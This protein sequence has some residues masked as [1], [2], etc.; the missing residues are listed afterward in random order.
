M[1][2][3]AEYQGIVKT[4]VVAAAALG[5]PGLLNPLLDSGGMT[6]IWTTMVGAIA[7]KSGHSIDPALVAKLVGGA[8]T[9]VA[10]YA[11][12]SKILTWVATPLI[13]AFPLAGVPAAA[14]VN[15]MLNGL[16]TYRLGLAVSS[17]MSKPDFTSEDFVDLGLKMSSYLIFLPNADE[18]NEVRQLLYS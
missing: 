12:G 10:G 11:L 14:G 5:V 17:Q 13:L 7:V 2:V 8:F 1:P 6:A 18:I 4:G 15:S 9:A 16:F 3:S